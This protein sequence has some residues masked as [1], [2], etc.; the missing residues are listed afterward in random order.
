MGIFKWR[1]IASMALLTGCAGGKILVAVQ[2]HSNA[3][4]L[5]D[6]DKQAVSAKIPVGSMPHEIV[7]DPVSKLCF[8]S[9]FGVED[10]DTK[11]GIPG[12]SISVIDPYKSILVKTIYTGTDSIGNMPHGIKI[13]PG[14]AHEL[15]VNIERGD[16]MIVYNLKN[17]AVIR[18]FAIPPLAHNFIFSKTGERLWLM[19]G[20]AGI[21]Q[22]NPADGK[23]IRQ[24]ILT[25]PVRG[26]AFINH[27]ILASCSNEVYIL[28]QKDLCIKEHFCN[29]GVGQILYSAVSKDQQYILCPAVYDST[30]LILEA[31]S[32]KIIARLQTD[33]TP[34]NIQTS[35]NL[36]FVSHAQDNHITEI[37][38]KT[39]SVIKNIEV[40]GT[41]GLLIINKKY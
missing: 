2:Q 24:Q 23:K 40:P 39:F 1:L 15:F 6:I 36:A 7:Y 28:S 4:L 5:Y 27:D 18:K 38:L 26:L 32:G 34:I 14:N 31:A 11:I 19:C 37:N 21:Y 12:R 20:A 9:D 29:L 41:N 22:V 17:Y 3:V 33:K 10:Y 30:V 16:S 25:S 35:G 13:R 8:V